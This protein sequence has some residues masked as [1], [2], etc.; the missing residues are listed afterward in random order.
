MVFARSLRNKDLAVKY[1]SL[2]DLGA[3]L[4]DFACG[5]PNTAGTAG[6]DLSSS[7]R[8]GGPPMHQ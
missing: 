1:F 2:N 5:C 7:W 8:R 6:I 3:M 4:A